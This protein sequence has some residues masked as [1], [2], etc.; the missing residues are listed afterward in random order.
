VPLLAFLGLL[1]SSSISACS[2]AQ[3]HQTDEGATTRSAGPPPGRGARRAKAIAACKG[4][5][6]GQA[7]KIVFGERERAGTC[8]LIPDGQLACLPKQT[9]ERRKR[10]RE[11]CKGK[12]AGD[13]CQV[14]GRNRKHEGT[15]IDTGQGLMCRPRRRG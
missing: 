14:Q 4:K 8:R 13:S 5:K 3:A 2:P 15:C 12:K 10:A 6:E 11:A 9:E 7:C 1:S